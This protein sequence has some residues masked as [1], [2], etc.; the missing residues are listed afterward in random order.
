MYPKYVKQNWALLHIGK[1]HYCFK[2]LQVIQAVK[3][4]VV[5]VELCAERIHVLELDEETILKEA[6]N[7]D[8][9]K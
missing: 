6:K 3:P 1:K 7:L 8:Y 9:S 2:L 5:V 4:E